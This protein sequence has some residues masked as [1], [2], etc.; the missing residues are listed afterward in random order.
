MTDSA[1]HDVVVIGGG[2][3]GLAAANK[4]AES[5]LRVA[6]LEQGTEELYLC[7]TRI[8]A[9]VFHVA[10]ETM[11]DPPEELRRRIEAAT[12]GYSQPSLADALAKDSARTLEWLQQQGVRFVK[13]NLSGKMRNMLAP[14]SV[15]QPGLNNWKG[16]AGDVM[17]RTLGTRLKEQS[18]TLLRGVR[19]TELLM[20]NGICTGVL[21]VSGG[22]NM[23]F[24][25][26]AVVIAD[27]GFQVNPEMVRQHISPAPE[28]V[29]RRNAG[30]GF[31]DGARMAQAAGAKLTG[32]NRFYGH[33]LYRDAMEN[34]RFWPYPTLDFLASGAIVVDAEARRFVDEGYGGTHIANAV[35]A[36]ADPL[37]ATIIFDSPIW[38]GPGRDYDL[39]P[40]PHVT[41]AGGKLVEAQTLEGLAQK[42]GIPA[43]AL[44]RTVS[45]YN[46][47]LAQ[48]ALDKL[49]PPRSA[50]QFKPWPIVAPPFLAM[51]VCAG[52]TYTMGGIATDEHGRVLRDDGLPISGLYAA[53]SSTGGLEGGECSGYA[54]GLAKA[55]VFGLRAG[56]CIGR[57]AKDG[58]PVAAPR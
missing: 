30:T 2:L 9:G 24:E 31:G 14:P 4:A 27:G 45:D 28:R 18:G 51:H 52:L 46:A 11:L 44:Q 20:R 22:E 37:G 10:R 41:N 6:V 40:N 3:A 12:C 16:R 5:G 7:N 34:D 54:G 19:A 49:S 15:R 1:I 56:E 21:A 26:S 57:S 53:G 48:G 23:R 13:A 50:H 25:C 58:V 39:P 33:L 35:A 8:T 38:N 43:E 32:L 42:L 36:L 47:N 29:M 55:A 17:L